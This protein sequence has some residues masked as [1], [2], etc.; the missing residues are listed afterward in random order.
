MFYRISFTDNVIVS[1]EETDEAY[2]L[3]LDGYLFLQEHGK[4]VF[5]IV[6]ADNEQ[7]AR[8][9]GLELINSVAPEAK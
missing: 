7:A 6:H 2:N 4:L 5:A 9:K 3:E 1:I 8:Q